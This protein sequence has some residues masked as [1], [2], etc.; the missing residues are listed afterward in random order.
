MSHLFLFIRFTFTSMF[1]LA[2]C[3]IF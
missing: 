2:V 3:I 1:L